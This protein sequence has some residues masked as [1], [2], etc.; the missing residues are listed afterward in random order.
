VWAA[1]DWRTSGLVLLVVCS[2]MVG[3]AVRDRLE[4][5]L[6]IVQLDSLHCS[7]GVRRAA[8]TI[9]IEVQD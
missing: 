5:S 7:G 6:I 3:N 4:S 8:R 2:G 1:R 9:L